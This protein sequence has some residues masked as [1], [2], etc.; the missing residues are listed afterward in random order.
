[1]P[2]PIPVY[3][4]IAE[5]NAAIESQWPDN[6]TRL[7]DPL[8]LRSVVLGIVKYITDYMDYKPEVYPFV[9]QSTVTLPLNA[10]RLQEFGYVPQPLVFLGDDTNGWFQTSVTWSVDLAPPDTTSITVDLAGPATGFII[11]K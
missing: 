4:T 9:S 10:D 1:M 6:T 3:H 7:I 11:L 5:V 8:R 2:T